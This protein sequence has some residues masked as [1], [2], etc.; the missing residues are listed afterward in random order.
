MRSLASFTQRDYFEIHPCCVFV[1][2]IDELYSAARIYHHLLTHSSVGGYLG[3]F[4]VWVLTDDA[5]M[6]VCG[7]ILSFFLGK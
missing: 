6:N 5:A 3:C 1:P 2:F 7:H 4:Q